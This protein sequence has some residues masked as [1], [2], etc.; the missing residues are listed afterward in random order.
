MQDIKVVI[1]NIFF[2]FETLLFVLFEFG[3]H[4][5]WASLYVVEIIE[6]FNVERQRFL[7]RQMGQKVPMG[8]VCPFLL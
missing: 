7:T 3:M 2:T 1:K 8:F 4:L 5:F 6:G